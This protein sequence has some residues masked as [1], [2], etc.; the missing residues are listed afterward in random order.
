MKNPT[1]TKTLGGRGT[2]E[3]VQ[4]SSRPPNWWAWRLPQYGPPKEPHPG[5]ALLASS[6]PNCP[7][8][9]DFVPT[10]LWLTT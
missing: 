4:R 2:E 6:S 3:V 10:P 7:R 1:C 5:S 9:V 8:N